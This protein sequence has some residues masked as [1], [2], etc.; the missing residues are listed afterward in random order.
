MLAVGAASSDGGC[1]KRRSSV[2]AAL[3]LAVWHWLSGVGYLSLAL[4]P[5]S[6]SLNGRTAA[7]TGHTPLRI[8]H[9]RRLACSTLSVLP[10][11]LLLWPR[12]GTQPG[13]LAA[14]PDPRHD[15]RSLAYHCSDGRRG[16]LQRAF[17]QGDTV[18]PP[19][20][21]LNKSSCERRWKAPNDHVAHAR[22]LV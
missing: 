22:S 13:C 3:P 8:S 12:Y 19:L 6:R 18:Q 11:S 10:W 17:G 4:R 1:R 5:V 2:V 16:W 7:G 21:W 20:L 15:P 9:D 14:R